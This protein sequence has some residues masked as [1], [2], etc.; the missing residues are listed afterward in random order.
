M[1]LFVLWGVIQM[2]AM[3]RQEPCA[4][5]AILALTLLPV[6]AWIYALFLHREIRTVVESAVEVPPYSR[7]HVLHR[8]LVGFVLLASF[9]IAQA[10]TVN[11]PKKG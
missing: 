4:S 1:V 3:Q 2:R 8:S 7:L 6:V 9:I 5:N 10:L 11:C